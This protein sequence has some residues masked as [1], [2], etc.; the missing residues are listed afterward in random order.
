[1]A[2]YFLL[3]A[4]EKNN[5]SFIILS[6]IFLERDFILI[7]PIG[8]RPH[9]FNDLIYYFFNYQRQKNI[10]DFWKLIIIW[11]ITTFIVALPMEYIFLKILKIL[12]AIYSSFSI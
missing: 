1:L 9:C 12:W 4:L 3:K 8:L 6:G 2:I 10:K 7:S 5:G 11:I